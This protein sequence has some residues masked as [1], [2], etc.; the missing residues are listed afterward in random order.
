VEKFF[1]F[2][3]S[4]GFQNNP[5]KFWRLTENPGNIF[6]FKKNPEIFFRACKK[7]LKIFFGKIRSHA[8]PPTRVI[9][10]HSKTGQNPQKT[11]ILRGDRNNGQ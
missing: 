2:L 11:P 7:F 5:K 9:P 3:R 4:R 6:Q 8:H 1:D 10:N